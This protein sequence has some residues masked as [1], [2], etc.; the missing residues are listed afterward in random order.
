MINT[1]CTSKLLPIMIIFRVMIMTMKERL[2]M[3]IFLSK[4]PNPTFLQIGVGVDD[5][6]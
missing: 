5:V 1:N 4:M 6:G 2:M 3:L